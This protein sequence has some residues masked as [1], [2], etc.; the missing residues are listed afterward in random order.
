MFKIPYLS[1]LSRLLELFYPVLTSGCS[2]DLNGTGQG[3]V[4]S[5]C[6]LLYAIM[7]WL[8]R[9]RMSAGGTRSFFTGVGDRVERLPLGLNKSDTKNTCG[10][11][12][13]KKT[14]TSQSLQRDTFKIRIN[15]VNYNNTE[16]CLEG[17]VFLQIKQ[18]LANIQWKCKLHI[19]VDSRLHIWLYINQLIWMPVFFDKLHLQIIP[20]VPLSSCF[21]IPF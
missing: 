15:A 12:R 21:L 14:W 17:E 10:G 5:I 11:N 7:R 6:S 19:I 13:K 1:A 4:Q 3:Y 16:I 2:S 9:S 20:P 8:L 18:S